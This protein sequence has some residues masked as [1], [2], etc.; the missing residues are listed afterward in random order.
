MGQ[1]VPAIAFGV[2]LTPDKLSEA[3]EKLHIEDD[4]WRGFGPSYMDQP[5]ADCPMH[6]NAT[7]SE[8]LG[9]VV[10]IEA[11]N[12]EHKGA[13]EVRLLPPLPLDTAA[14]EAFVGPKPMRRAR[15]LWARLERE[16]KAAGF[17]L[18]SP[19]LIVTHVE[20]A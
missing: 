6:S 5:N 13:R 3:F 16:A 12:C 11:D 10:V 4:G 18:G 14:V 1:C 7:D 15:R 17:V 2:V 20:T 19:S 8:V 9:F